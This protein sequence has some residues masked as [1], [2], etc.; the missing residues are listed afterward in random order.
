MYCPKCG[1]KKQDNAILCLICGFAYEEVL[2][3]V[4]SQNKPTFSDSDINNRGASW[5]TLH[6]QET[7]WFCKQKSSEGKY[8]K[9]VSMKLSLS[10]EDT[11]FETREKFKLIDIYVPRCKQCDSVHTWSGLKS[12]MVFGFIIIAVFA[13]SQI[14]YIQFFKEADEGKNTAAPYLITLFVSGGIITRIKP[15]VDGITHPKEVM[16]VNHKESFP[17]VNLLLSQGWRILD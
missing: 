16:P 10:V 4:E 5:M 14:V 7:C 6:N 13:I 2:E 11:A 9:Q 1:I 3:P 8:A 17:Q 12:A 15:F